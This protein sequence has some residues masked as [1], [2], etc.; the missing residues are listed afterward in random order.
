MP[1]QRA[2]LR[3]RFFS[4]TRRAE[5]GCLEWIG[6]LCHGYGM[7]YR[8]PKKTIISSRMAWILEHGDIAGGLCVLHRCDNQLCVDH[9]HLFLGTRTDNHLDKVAK[10]RSNRGMRHGHV[11][12]TDEQVLQIRAMNGTQRSIADQL[13]VDQG[14]ISRIKNRKYWTHI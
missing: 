4:Y 13:G 5:N 14:L 8:S 3:E 1:K 9:S 6:C 12:L 10:G 7:F 2:S 11:K